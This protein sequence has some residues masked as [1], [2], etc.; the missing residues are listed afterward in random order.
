MVF[1]FIFIILPLLEIFTFIG[2][3]DEIGFITTFLLCVL[4]AMVGI[5]LV[6]KQG[7]DTIRR[8]QLD[9]NDGNFPAQELFNGLCL[10]IA[11]A[12]LIIPGFITD[13]MA[14]ALLIPPVREWLKTYAVRHMDVRVQTAGYSYS[15]RPV[16]N[17]NILEGT[18]ERVDE[19]DTSDK[20]P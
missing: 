17:G 13:A 14:F 11:G 5:T 19:D 12:L 6:Q 7:F 18:Y 16:D 20:R 8:A 9:L 3:I 10:F 1:L 15:E 4:S 2:V